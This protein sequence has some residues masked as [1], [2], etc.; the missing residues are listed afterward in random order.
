MRYWSNVFAMTGAA[1]LAIFMLE[2]S[3]LALLT[4]LFNALLGFYYYLKDGKPH[5]DWINRLANSYGIPSC[6]FAFIQAWNF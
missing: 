3:W 4:G 2:F 6:H 1:C 5:D